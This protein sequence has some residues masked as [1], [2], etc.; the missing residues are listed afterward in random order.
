LALALGGKAAEPEPAPIVIHRQLQLFVDTAL[1]EH[2]DGV[3][4]QLQTPRPAEVALKFDAPWEGSGNHY[5]TVF[6]DG[7]RYRMYYR[8]WHRPHLLPTSQDHPATFICCAESG[9]GIAWHRPDLGLFDYQ[10]SKHNNIVWPDMYNADSDTGALLFPVLNDRPGAPPEL[11]YLAPGAR[12]HE[13]GRKVVRLYLFASADGYRWRQLTASPMFDKASSTFYPSPNLL[14]ADESLFWDGDLQKYVIYLRDQWIAPG[15]GELMRGVRRA[16]SA[17]LEHWSY[18]EWIHLRPQP[19]EQFYTSGIRPYYRE[20]HYYFSFPMR[21]MAHRTAP[22]PPEL[23]AE[24]DAGVTDSVFMSS[25]DGLHW[26]RTFLEAFLRPGLDPLKWT[27]RSNNLGRGPV[28]TG[29]AEMSLYA[30]EYF[31]LPHPQVRRYTLRP[32]GVAS[33]HAGYPGGCLVTKPIIFSGHRLFVNASTSAAG[34]VRVEVLTAAGEPIDRYSGVNAIE[35][36]G[37]ETAR[38]MRWDQGPDIG[39]LAGRSVRLRF[40]LRDADLFSFHFSD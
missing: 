10:G 37:D 33:A 23:D 24:R 22:M 8:A 12:L 19:P 13:K 25:R 35:F 6:K 5:V 27:D 31:R 34:G 40:L 36:F 32:D 29:P 7:D 38:E 20:P 4:L 15:T 26:D 18:P 16:T 2:A 17:D 14:D 30:L 3:R 39:A 28:P 9:D 21:Y 1:I 11:R